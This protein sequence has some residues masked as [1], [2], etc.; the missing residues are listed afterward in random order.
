MKF[1]FVMKY[2]L[3]DS[4]SLMQKF[5]GEMNAV[6]N[7]GHEVYYISFDRDYLY[8]DNGK[9]REKL[10]KT[11]LGHMKHYFHTFVFYDIYHA[12][13]KVIT[14]NDFDVVYFRF[15][16]L[17]RPGCQMMQTAARRSKLVVEI[18]SYPP[19]NEKDKNMLRT[20]YQRRTRRLWERYA[21][22]VTLF[23]GVGEH[24]DSFL[25]V[26]FLNIDNGIDVSLI[27]PREEN[28]NVD[29]KIHLLAVASMCVW[30]GYERVIEGLAQWDSAEA[31][32]YVFDLVGNDGDGSLAQWKKLAEERGLSGQVIF[33]GR[34]TGDAL[35]EMYN[36][37]TLGVSTLAL[38]KKKF[39]TGSVLKLREYMAR[40]LPFI[41][42]H[43]DPH[44]SADM[45][46]CFQIPNDDSP[47]PMQL[48]HRF[49][50]DVLAEQNLSAQMRTYAKEHM[51]WESQFKKIIKKLGE[52]T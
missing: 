27:P 29:G 46:W 11:T 36:Q 12:V 23:S 7:L 43:D 47:V 3:V 15:S 52:I 2:P 24:T 42:A 38:Y 14:E 41:Y 35:T 44:M 34:M 39:K 37:A 26:P 32:R 4:Y 18:P 21:N 17:N 5:N 49:V 19:F 13:Q 50:G 33:H 10:Q 16:P 25:G 48:V 8:L 28:R 20:V 22:C 40:G 9:K 1:L 45:K 31:K 6:R 30:Q 51:S